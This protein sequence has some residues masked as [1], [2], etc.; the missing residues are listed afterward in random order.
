MESEK[1]NEQDYT[2][3]KVLERQTNGW[4]RIR[5]IILRINLYDEKI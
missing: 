5:Y 2:I 3:E 1:Y 4:D